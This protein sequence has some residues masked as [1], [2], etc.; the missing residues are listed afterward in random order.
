MKRKESAS[1]TSPKRAK[2]Q[3]PRISLATM[4]ISLKAMDPAVSTALK[5]AAAEH[6]KQHLGKGKKGSA[7]MAADAARDSTFPFLEE[8]DAVHTAAYAAASC[9]VADALL[10]EAESLPQS[11]K[12]EKAVAA[13]RAADLALLRGGVGDWAAVTKRLITKAVE[14][15]ESCEQD[16]T[17]KATQTSPKKKYIPPPPQF[18]KTKNARSIPRVDA[19][20]LS[21]EE[22]TKQYMEASPPRPVIL[23]HVVDSWPAFTRWKDVEYLKRVAEGRLV[24]VETYAKED[25][26]QSFLSKSWSHQIIPLDEYIA[27]FV[28]PTGSVQEGDKG[29]QGYL[30]Q[31]PLF[32]Q[33]PALRKDIITPSY[34]QAHTA[35][36]DATP[37]DCGYRHEPFVSAWFGPAG[38]VSP[39]HN[40]PY[41]NVLA[42]IVGSKYLRIYDAHETDRIYQRSDHL[43][44]NS[45]V[46]I[47]NPNE[48]AVKFPLFKDAPCW[49]TI[50]K[51]GELLYMP[52]HVWHYVK[53]L[54]TSF[55][56][57]FWFGSKT[58]LV[59][60]AEGKYETQYLKKHV[61]GKE[62]NIQ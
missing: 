9:F 34:C 2:V 59:K 11:L 53:S 35:E 25:A 17:P 22:F 47:D 55:S 33:I 60:T 49:Q 52:R 32:D 18:L 31:H 43:G 26:G 1:E 3:P 45:Q 4:P 23:T 37:D 13:L 10:N 46:D 27:R 54:E 41:H 14:I 61:P 19:R 39:L 21:V 15:K 62:L 20:S 24:P 50:L 57:S 38:T 30:A 51:E 29:I 8:P 6:L 58:E 42:Q 28:S 44:H 36:D 7:F 48:I 56:A 12:R 5:L 40:D 16:W